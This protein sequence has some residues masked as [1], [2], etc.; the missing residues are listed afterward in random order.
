MSTDIATKGRRPSA[1]RRSAA[2]CGA[3]CGDVRDQASSR[4][5]AG[6]ARSGPIA[7]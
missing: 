1:L 7:E 5:I 2:L 3:V 6:R 4:G